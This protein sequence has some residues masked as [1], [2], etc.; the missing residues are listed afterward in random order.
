MPPT[1][2]I[3]SVPIE[4]TADS[5]AQVTTCNVDKLALLG[6]RL[7]LAGGRFTLPAESRYSPTEEECLAVAVGLEQSKFSLWGVLGFTLQQ[8]RS[9]WLEYHVTGLWILLAIQ[10]L[11]L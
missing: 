11:F 9:H 2:K 10:G 8:I 4:L 3:R 5:G 7:V 1:K 6:W